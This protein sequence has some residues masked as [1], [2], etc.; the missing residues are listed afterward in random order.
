MKEYTG[1]LLS[2]AKG[3]LELAEFAFARSPN[4]VAFHAQQCVE[5]SVKAVA[6]ELGQF[7]KE[8]EFR[9]IAKL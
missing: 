3:D 8:S 5:K 2:L 1:T 7:K 6:Y 4:Q 9:P